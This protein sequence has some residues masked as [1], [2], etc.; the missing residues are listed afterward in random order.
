[1][2]V[3]IT[4]RS[5]L[6][7]SAAGALGALSSCSSRP[8]SAAPA[9]PAPA[10]PDPS[11]EDP[12]ELD[13]YGY[14]PDVAE[15]GTPQPPA[16]LDH[17]P[18]AASVRAD[19]LPPVGRQHTN[20]CFVWSSIY[21]LAT[22]HAA[23]QSQTPPTSPDR[24]AAPDYSYIRYM[25]AHKKAGNTCIGG[26]VTTSLDWLR[27]NGGTPSLAAAPN[28]R[29]QT[30]KESC[31]ANWSDYSTKTIA[32]DPRFL[33]SDYKVTQVTGADGLNNLRTVIAHGSPIAFGT[34]LY[35]DFEHYRGS[36]QSYVGNGKLLQ[37]SNGKKKGHAM[38]IV[39][40]D[41]AHSHGGGAVRIQNSWGTR[42]GDKGFAWVAYDTFEKLASPIGAY[43]AT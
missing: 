30:D 25:L 2:S 39:G 26:L 22:F 40:Y 20:N 12:A 27:S 19:W 4:R 33:I 18:P 29:K 6:V 37:S 13:S 28:H 31:R 23:R 41:D 32:P 3:Q 34:S 11:D 5:M 14:D 36:P 7:L 43:L 17:L 10:T 9:T 21:G 15:S 8:R 35:T 16:P 38:L 24:Q 42:W 1:M